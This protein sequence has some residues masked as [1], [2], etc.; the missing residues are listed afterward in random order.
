MAL[1]QG[2]YTPPGG[3]KKSRP[4]TANTTHGGGR[5]MMHHGFPHILYGEDMGK[6]MI[7][8]YFLHPSFGVLETVDAHWT[9]S[10][11]KIALAKRAVTCATCHGEDCSACKGEGEFFIPA[12]DSFQHYHARRATVRHCGIYKDDLRATLA[13]AIEA[14][15][16]PEED[17][18]G[19]ARLCPKCSA[20][21]CPTCKGKGETVAIVW[22]MHK[23]L[24]PR[25]RP[26]MVKPGNTN[27]PKT[28][29]T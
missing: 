22:V 14:P 28:W 15:P 19:A 11:W 4:R 26:I 12:G 23:H 9:G 2:A 13:G 3:P 6:I 7:P 10:A 25:G 29:R 1:H 27:K 21:K 8:G 18:G 24:K 5:I 17:P 16:H 20:K